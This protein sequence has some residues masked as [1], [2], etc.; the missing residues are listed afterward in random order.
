VTSAC[1][2][3]TPGASGG[4][5]PEFNQFARGNGGYNTD[6]NNVA[7]NVGVAWRPRVESGW[8]RALLGDPEQATIRAGYSVAYERQGSPSSPACSARIPAARSA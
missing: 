7:P 8:L 4:K 3:F 1:R 5:V 2:F 6:W